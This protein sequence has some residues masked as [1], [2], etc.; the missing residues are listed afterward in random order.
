MHTETIKTYNSMAGP[1]EQETEGFWD[2]FPD[3]I[4]RKYRESVRGWRVLDIGS[5]PG[6]DGLILRNTDLDVVCLDA[7]KK[8]V[9]RAT[10]RGLPSVQ[11][12]FLNLP[13]ANQSFDGVWAYT[14]LLHVD[15]SYMNRALREIWRVLV[16]NGVFGLGMIEGEGEEIRYTLEGE[17]RLFVYYQKEDLRKRLNSYSFQIIHFEQFKPRTSNYLNFLALKV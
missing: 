11:A 15:R 3:A 17:P 10:E 2:E 8:M 12:D 14:S 9:E 13:F 1:Y 5:G 16:P 7:A 6:R 4:F